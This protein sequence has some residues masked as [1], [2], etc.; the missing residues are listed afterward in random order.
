MGA[1]CSPDLCNLYAFAYEL[2][3]LRTNVHEYL[4]PPTEENQADRDTA[5]E[6][7]LA[8]LYYKRYLDDILCI[9]HIGDTARDLLWRAGYL[10]AGTIFPPW[11]PLQNTSL[12]T[13]RSGNFMDI[14][15][16]W[17]PE[18]RR[19]FASLY[20]KRRNTYFRGRITLLTLPIAHSCLARTCK[21][22]VVTSQLWRFRTLC[23]VWED[24]AEAATEFCQR[25]LDAGYT[26]EELRH[27]VNLVLPRVAPYYGQKVTTLRH[28]LPIIECAKPRRPGP[29]PHQRRRVA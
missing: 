26:A 17:N 25:F 27:G 21:H 23:T 13:F 18:G 4:A 5:G 3:F 28:H 15:F 6:V 10:R 14:H 22:T 8:L 16:R 1:S 2:A 29:P 7:L 9:S 12:V 11:I 19:L 20:D 24:W